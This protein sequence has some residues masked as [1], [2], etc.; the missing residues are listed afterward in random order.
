MGKIE[1]NKIN[2]ILN[3]TALSD[4]SVKWWEKQVEKDLLNLEELDAS[5][6]E[7]DPNKRQELIDQ[8]ML[9]L[10]RS[11]IELK[12]IYEIEKEIE[13]FIKQQN[14]SKKSKNKRKPN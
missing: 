1:E 2:E 5:L 13:D 7:I 9:I 6:S 4:S 12:I 8:L 10:N 14:K 3:K 11:E